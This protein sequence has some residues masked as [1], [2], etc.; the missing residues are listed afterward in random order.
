MIQRNGVPGQIGSAEWRQLVARGSG[1]E[2]QTPQWAR[3]QTSLGKIP[4]VIVR[5]QTLLSGTMTLSIGRLP[6]RF[7]HFASGPVFGTGLYSHADFDKVLCDI[8]ELGLRLKVAYVTFFPGLED[9]NRDA[10][11]LLTAHGF[12][13]VDGFLPSET[14]LIDLQKP[15][16]SLWDGLT[17]STRKHVRRGESLGLKLR[18]GWD[19][20]KFCQMWPMATPSSRDFLRNLHAEVD[21][22]EMY[23]A[24]SQQGTVS[25]ALTVKSASRVKYLLGGTN[26]N[27]SIGGEWL[28]WQLIMRA[29]GVSS[30][31]DL[32]GAMV[33][34]RCF[35]R[36]SAEQRKYRGVAEFKQGFGGSLTR[37]LGQFDKAYNRSVYKY[38]TWGKTALLRA[39]PTK[40]V[41]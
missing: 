15:M 21:G 32:G 10:Y 29:K 18:A 38:L 11:N 14:F 25:A 33:T 40:W 36:S 2:S 30:H 24:D 8:D 17:R 23:F 20:E 41:L 4:I 7:L 6:I 31:F 35:R 1:D 5:N 34:R 28:L 26:R 22:A 37:Y 39:Y 12:Q 3:L 27:V 13:Q 16:E 9:D 19:I